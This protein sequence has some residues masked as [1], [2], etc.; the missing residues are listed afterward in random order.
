M[1]V[2]RTIT[3][4]GIDVPF[5]ASAAIPRI[6]RNKFRRD[7]YRDLQALGKAVDTGNERASELELIDLEMFEDL[8][9]VMAKHADSTVSDEPDVW[10]EQFN[11]FSI[12]Q[13]L[14][15][16]IELWGLNIETK[17]TPPKN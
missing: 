1:A 15:Q 17:V 14:P 16:L 11:T 13:I 4:D 5:R 9:W 12:Y 8:A 3:I 6:Y 7:I 2:T 10:L